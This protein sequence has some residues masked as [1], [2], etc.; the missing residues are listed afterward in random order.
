MGE[1]T[2]W[3]LENREQTR[4]LEIPE[5]YRA[6]AL[7]PDGRSAAIGLDDGIQLIDLRTGAVRESRGTLASNP[8]WLLFSPD[9]K[10]IVST[11]RDG[12]VT[13]WDAGTLIPRETLRGHSDSVWQPVFSPDGKTLYT[14][15]ADGTTIVWDVSGERWFGRR[16]TFTDDR[17]AWEWPDTP[18][19]EVQ[20]GRA[21]DRRRPQLDGIRLW[22]ARTL[23]PV[24]G[25]RWRPAA[26][27]ST[28][29]SV[30]TDRR[31]RPSAG[32]AWR[33]SGIVESR[34]VRQGPFRS[35]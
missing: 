9:G 29:R 2:W 33:R 27:S 8:I 34:S 5:G 31:S 22:D 23:T 1:L 21:D 25:P 3:D 16:F 24:A 30:R 18:P 35:T 13:L 28:L 14:A 15:S 19:G 17:G 10:S 11:S 12:T 7:S 6:L 32:A 20:P 26:R 4:T